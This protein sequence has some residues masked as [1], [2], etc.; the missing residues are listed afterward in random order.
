MSF[1]FHQEKLLRISIEK[2]KASIFDGPCIRELMKDSMF[3]ETLS[4]VEPPTGSHG[5]Q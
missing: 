3:D 2:L 5:S 1:A 4:E